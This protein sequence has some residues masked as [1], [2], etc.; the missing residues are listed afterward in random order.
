MKKFELKIGYRFLQPK[1]KRIVLV[2]QASYSNV[3]IKF[4]NNISVDKGQVI[5]MAY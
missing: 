5:M 2:W 4:I 3:T 1:L